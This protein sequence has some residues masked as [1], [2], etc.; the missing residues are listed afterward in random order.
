MEAKKYI[1]NKYAK[2]YSTRLSENQ[3]SFIDVT[4]GELKSLNV[5]F[6]GYVNI[7]GVH[8]IHP[9]SNVITGLTQAGGVDINGSLRNVQIIRNGEIFGTKD[10][11][12]YLSTGK[13]LTDIRLLDQDIVL[14][15]ARKSTIAITGRVKSPVT[16]S[17]MAI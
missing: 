5:H 10:M 16:M 11:Y 4:L 2:I 12:T 13:A 9:F 14:L 15:P 8:M 17:Q 6:V 1:T 7:P 3:K